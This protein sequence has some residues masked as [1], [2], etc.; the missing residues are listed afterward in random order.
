MDENIHFIDSDDF[1]WHVGETK[2]DL[3]P[4]IA[5]AINEFLRTIKVDIWADGSACFADDEPGYANYQGIPVIV[6]GPDRK[7][8]AIDFGVD[9][10]KVISLADISRE[11]VRRCLEYRDHDSALALAAAL[12]ILASDLELSLKSA[13]QS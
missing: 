6:L 4:E 12:R 7:K 8:K 3:G 2:I 1:A 11:T 5:N 10:F 13:G 9:W